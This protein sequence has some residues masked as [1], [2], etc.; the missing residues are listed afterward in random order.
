MFTRVGDV[1]ALSRVGVVRL[2]L[3]TH[4]VAVAGN[5]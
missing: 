5:L 2:K 4:D 1:E 3:Q